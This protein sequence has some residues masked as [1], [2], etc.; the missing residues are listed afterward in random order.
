MGTGYWHG[1]PIA[2]E[3]PAD[4]Q[5][6]MRIWAFPSMTTLLVACRIAEHNDGPPPTSCVDDRRCALALGMV[7]GGSS[8]EWRWGARRS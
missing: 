3:L 7:S 4:N 5:S 8:L 6:L 2:H 1:Q